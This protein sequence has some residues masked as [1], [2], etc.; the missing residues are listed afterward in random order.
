MYRKET[1][2][3]KCHGQICVNRYTVQF[4]PFDESIVGV[5]IFLRNVNPD[6][7]R[8]RKV[9]WTNAEV[10]VSEGLIVSGLDLNAAV[11]LAKMIKVG[12]AMVT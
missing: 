10:W 12:I 11:E 7:V 4:L 5:T 9:G 8:Q 6:V 1:N 2:G 3:S